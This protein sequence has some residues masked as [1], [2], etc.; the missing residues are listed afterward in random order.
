MKGKEL[1]EFA[2]RIDD[3]AVVEYKHYGWE[4]LK[5]RDLRAC[6]MP[7]FTQDQEAPDA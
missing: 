2:Q 5:A 7:P 6:T 3:D 1:K 4:P